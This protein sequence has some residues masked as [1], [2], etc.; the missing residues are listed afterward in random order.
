MPTNAK[1]LLEKI[2][3][4]PLPKKI[5]IM[6]VYGG[7][8]R[9]ISMSGLRTALPP[10]IELIR[11]PGC[12]AC[13]CPGEDI[14]QAIQIVGHEDVVLLAFGDMLR[15]PVNVPKNTIRTLEQAKAADADIRPIASP[16][17]DDKITTAKP[18]KTVV[19]FVAGFEK[20]CAPD[21]AMLAEGTG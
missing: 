4:L 14:Y 16:S 9:S 5:R 6:N 13:I 15:F 7:H 21:A 10:N 3:G 18:G 19:F 8:E 1:L 20:T 11:G 17:E 12:S 2:R